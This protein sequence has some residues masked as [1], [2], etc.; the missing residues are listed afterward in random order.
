[1]TIARPVTPVLRTSN[2]SPDVDWPWPAA[3]AA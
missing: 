3:Q 1:M 2:R